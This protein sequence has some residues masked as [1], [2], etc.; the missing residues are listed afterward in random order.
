[1]IDI[2]EIIDKVAEKHPYRKLGHYSSQYNEG[3]QDACDKISRLI[4]AE[5]DSIIKRLS[6]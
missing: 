1:M 4:Q 3:W 6:K 5:E 2:N